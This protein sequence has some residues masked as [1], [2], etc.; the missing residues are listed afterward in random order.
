MVTRCLSLSGTLQW[1][2]SMCIPAP[3]RPGRSCSCGSSWNC[4]HY[5]QSL[6]EA[7]QRSGSHRRDEAG[8]GCDSGKRLD[9]FV[10]GLLQ[11]REEGGK[12]KKRECEHNQIKIANSSADFPKKT[13]VARVFANLVYN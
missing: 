11:H 8:Q 5:L 3:R 10:A 7:L 4:C 12:L 9:P 6:A 2:V 1:Q 13:F